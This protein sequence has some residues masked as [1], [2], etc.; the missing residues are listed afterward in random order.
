MASVTHSHGA[1]HPAQEHGQ[2]ESQSMR[3]HYWKLLAMTIVSFVAMFVL[4]YAMVDRFDNAYL[5]V[6]KAYMAGLMTAPMVI[7]ELAFMG[8][9]Y[10]VRKVNAAIFAASVIALVGLWAAIRTQAGVGDVEFLRSMI[11]HHAS[12]VLMCTE[13]PV[14]RPDIQALCREIVSSQEREINEMK[15][16]LEWGR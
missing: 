3:G 9:M 1:R 14:T 12:A 11:P 16:M 8:S 13:A 5:N 10:P 7:A 4:M 6:N 15:A 2:H